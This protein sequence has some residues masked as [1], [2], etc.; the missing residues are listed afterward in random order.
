MSGA[1]SRRIPATVLYA[2]ETGRSERFARQLSEALDAV[3][4]SNVIRMDE[5]DIEK[6][7]EEKFLYIV[8]STFGD[9]LPPSSGMEY[10]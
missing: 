5:Y 7:K 8:T 9:G 1:R 10:A 2:T 4:Q 6:L 3:F